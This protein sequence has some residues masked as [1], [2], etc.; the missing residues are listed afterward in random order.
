MAL[1]FLGRWYGATAIKWTEGQVG[2]LPA[3]YRWF[4]RAVDKAG[5]LMVLLMP[6]SNLVCM[7]A[8]L[9]ADEPPTVPAL[10]QHR[11]RRQAGRAVGRRQAC[12]RTRSAR[13]SNSIDQYQWYIVGGLFAI[14][15]LQS[16]RKAKRNLP[17]ILHEIETPTRH[18]ASSADLRRRR[19]VPTQHDP[20]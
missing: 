2:E 3:I 8:G 11:H 19:S 17:E 5:W 12:S 10:H 16:M 14:T 4:Q 7:M 1:F 13:S 15:F 9:P 18:R 20:N 6:G